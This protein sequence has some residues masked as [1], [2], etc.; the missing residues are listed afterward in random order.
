MT[1]EQEKRAF[2]FVRD[3]AQLLRQDE[4]LRGRE[5]G[6]SWIINA[7]RAGGGLKFLN[8]ETIFAQDKTWYYFEVVNSCHPYGRYICRLSRSM[9]SDYGIDAPLETVAPLY[10][11]DGVVGRAMPLLAASAAPERVPGREAP[12]EVHGGCTKAGKSTAADLTYDKLV[13]VMDAVNEKVKSTASLP[14]PDGSD[15][16]AEAFARAEYERAFTEA[17]QE[18][19]DVGQPNPEQAF[20]LFFDARKQPSMQDT[21]A[22]LS[23]YVQFRSPS[24]EELAGQALHD[25]VERAYRCESVQ[26]AVAVVEREARICWR[27]FHLEFSREAVEEIKR[28]MEHAP[29][30]PMRV[31]D[32]A[33]ALRPGESSFSA[34]AGEE[35]KERKPK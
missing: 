3:V 14:L 35:H 27:S 6:L 17:M 29:S 23:Q 19:A 5:P 7:L 31:F 10:E 9:L 30:M 1:P 34:I 2:E 11:K 20:R 21:V 22:F 28:E 33:P 4:E 15:L 8:T 12:A 26:D 18:L 32:R 13:E 16:F 24:G 25:L